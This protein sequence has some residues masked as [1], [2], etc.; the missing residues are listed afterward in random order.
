MVETLTESMERKKANLEIANNRLNTLR[1]H[2]NEQFEKLS[3]V[4][5]QHPDY[6]SPSFVFLPFEEIPMKAIKDELDQ[7]M[8]YLDDA[9]R[10]YVQLMN[11]YERVKDKHPEL[12]DKYGCLV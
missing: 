4:K 7:K 2:Y 11:E 8:V 9:S 5:A 10:H 12:F 3:T 6:I 1:K